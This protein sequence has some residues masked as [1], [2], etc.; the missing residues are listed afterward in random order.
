MQATWKRPKS[1]NGDAADVL[2]E[3]HGFETAT[4]GDGIKP[5]AI[6]SEVETGA[7]KYVELKFLT[8]EREA[9]QQ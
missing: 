4:F 9:A 2:V 1:S 7:M 6:V 5:V 3:I 8:L